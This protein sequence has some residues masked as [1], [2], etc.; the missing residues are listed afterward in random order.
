MENILPVRSMLFDDEIAIPVKLKR[1]NEEKERMRMRCD[2]KMHF[3]LD[4]NCSAFLYLTRFN[5]SIGVYCHG[6]L[7]GS[8]PN[9]AG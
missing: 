4:T 5:R 3:L 1:G 8:S 6:S 9:T 2:V 7:T